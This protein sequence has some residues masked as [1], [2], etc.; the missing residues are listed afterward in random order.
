M[1][2]PREDTLTDHSYDGIQEFD[3]PLPGWWKALFWVTV[4]FSVL[5]W[6]WFHVY[7]GK[8]IVKHWESEVEA[9]RLAGFGRF[10][11]LAP[12]AENLVR[13][14]ADTDARGVGATL[15]KT[16]I[17]VTCH[18]PDGGGV[19]ALGANFCDDDAVNFTRIDEIPNI[20]RDGVP[21]TAM[22]AQGSV[23]S[24]DE[25][26]LLAAYVASLRGT[27]PAN[28]RPPHEKDRPIPPWPT[29]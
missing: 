4:G 18:G 16:R 27:A 17:C 26:T 23:L 24:S 21:N 12:T 5:Y 2:E 13:L 28:P 25:I 29:F 22:V 15:Y 7:P 11:D 19:P 9:A 6:G 14:M 8:N 20:I 10:G 1:T 3:N